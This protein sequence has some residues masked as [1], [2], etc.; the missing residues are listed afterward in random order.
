[1]DFREYEVVRQGKELVVVGTVRDPVNWDFTIRICEDDVPGL[2][3]LAARR[4]MLGMLLG[5]LFKWKKHHHWSQAHTEHITEGRQRLEAT[6]A[7]AAER[8]RKSLEPLTRRILRPARELARSARSVRRPVTDAARS[9]V[10][11]ESE[12]EAREAEAS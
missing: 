9:A 2:A 12:S 3:R 4:S 5:S 11:T 1:M 7:N 8:A 6:R 10:E